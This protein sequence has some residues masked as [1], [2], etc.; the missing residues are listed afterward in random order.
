MIPKLTQAEL[1]EL[2]HYDELTGIFTW[3]KTNSNKRQA[4]SK[5]GSIESKNWGNAYVFIRVNNRVYRGHTLACMYM[6]G[7]W[8]GKCKRS[9][10]KDGYGTNNKWANLKDAYG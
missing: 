4:G 3:A 1:K 7:K 10:H 2:L 6:T 8:P 9:P 5:A